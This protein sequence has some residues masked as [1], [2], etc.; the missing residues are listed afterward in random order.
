MFS[1]RQGQPTLLLILWQALFDQE[2]TAQRWLTFKQAEALGGHVR[3]GE[4]GVTVCYADRFTPRGEP[5]SEG[6]AGADEGA[7][8]GA[9]DEARKVAFLKRF[10]VFNVAQCDGLPEHLYEAEDR[11]QRADL[12]T[13]PEAEALI[14]ASGAN[15]AVGSPNACYRPRADRIEVPLQAAFI[16]PIN[17]YRTVLHELGHWTGHPSRLDRDQTGRFGTASYGC[18]ELV[19]EMCSAFTCAALGIVPTVRHS[20]YIA[21]WL[22]VLKGDNRAI[23][24]A[25]S[26][27]SK[28]ADFLLAF[29]SGA[30]A[31]V[32]AGGVA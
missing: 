27:A 24:R 5:G 6:G 23:F 10:T 4:R 25:A 20:D 12:V 14:A 18:E 3:K 21:C 28:A 32:D 9:G 16:E 7:P 30:D 22:E 15:I 29:R 8:S 31:A 26:Q 13:I 19:A 17:Y 1:L 11:E 2:F